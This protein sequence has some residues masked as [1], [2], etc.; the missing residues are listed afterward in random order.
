MIEHYDYML[1][2]YKEYNS[3]LSKDE[4]IELLNILEANGENY[5]TF[6][7][8]IFNGHEEFCGIYHNGGTWDTQKELFLTLQDHHYFIK[9]GELKNYLVEKMEDIL[10]DAESFEDVHTYF[11]WELED[12]TTTTDG[13]VKRFDY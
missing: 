12:M 4:F 11:N 5:D 6:Y 3:G 8:A 7:N 9:K 2:H 13:H 1:K 10:N